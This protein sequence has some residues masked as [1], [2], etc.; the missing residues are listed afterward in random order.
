MKGR[1]AAGCAVLMA[2]V[3]LAASAHPIVQSKC[4]A[5]KNKCMSQQAGSL[6]KCEQKAEMPSD[7]PVEPDLAKCRAKATTKFDGDGIAS[8]SCFG[9]LE[10]KSPNDCVTTGDTLT[11]E[12]LIDGCVGQIV[13]AIDPGAIDK[14]KCGVAKKKC[15]SKKLKSLLK[16]YAKAQKPGKPVD[17]SELDDCLA[18]AMAKFDGGAKPDKGCFAKLEAKRDN[19]CQPPT[20]N[21]AEVEA[22]IDSCSGAFVAFVEAT[23]PAESTT[24]AP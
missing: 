2:G 13:D 4:V 22:V 1:D 17:T 24:A 8:K 15:A 12:L 7:K 10:G 21:S 18:T 16:C 14:S 5:G 20:G 6:L 19:D 3:L 9:K 11:A 23:G